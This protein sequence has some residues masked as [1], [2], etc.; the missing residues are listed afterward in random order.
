MSSTT[1]ENS[2]EN[3]G[4]ICC[5]NLA[6]TLQLELFTDFTIITFLYDFYKLQAKKRNQRNVIAIWY[7]HSSHSPPLS[8]PTCEITY[9][10]RSS[11]STYCSVWARTTTLMRSCT[12][13][14]KCFLSSYSE[15]WVF[16]DMTSLQHFLFCGFACLFQWIFHEGILVQLGIDL[17][18]KISVIKFLTALKFT[19][20]LKFIIRLVWQMKQSIIDYSSCLG[21]SS[22]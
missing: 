19:I 1:S 20:L 21:F 2:E 3:N 9:L 18:G 5:S 16:P 15:L 6:F 22:G 4:K 8:S 12:M 7:L 13:R 14:I 11:V 10:L 17:Y